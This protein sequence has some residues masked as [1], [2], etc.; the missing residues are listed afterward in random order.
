MNAETEL[1]YARAAI[2]QVARLGGESTKLAMQYIGWFAPINDKMSFEHIYAHLLQIN[3]I[4]TNCT[5]EQWQAAIR[6]MLDN[7]ASG[8]LKMPLTDHALLEDYLAL[9]QDSERQ[10]EN[11]KPTSAYPSDAR[12]S[13]K[14]EMPPF[15]PPTAEQKAQAAER[16]QAMKQTCSRTRRIYPND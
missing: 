10:P 9:V 4:W 11:D 3:E 16:L 15:V 1:R 12:L 6:K 7:K 8:S 14:P 5:A 2:W 13:P